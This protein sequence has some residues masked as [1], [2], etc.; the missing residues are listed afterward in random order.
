MCNHSELGVVESAAEHC[1]APQPPLFAAR[2]ELPS[3]QAKFK[4]RD[5]VEGSFEWFCTAQTR[6]FFCVAVPP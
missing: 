3:H 6:T 4:S 5:N 2:C 1:H